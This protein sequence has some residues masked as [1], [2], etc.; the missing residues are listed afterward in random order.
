MN[1]Q[2]AIP[3]RSAGSGPFFLV[4]DVETWGLPAD[5]D[6]PVDRPGAW[7]E[8]IEVAWFDSAI[9]PKL[10]LAEDA[11]IIL[12]FWTNTSHLPLRKTLEAIL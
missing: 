9:T 6:A 2:K 12:L 7:P 1:S 4:L 5:F 10:E 8:L 3:S 11:L